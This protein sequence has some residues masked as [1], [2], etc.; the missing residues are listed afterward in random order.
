MSASIKI[1]GLAALV[2]QLERLGAVGGLKVC[3]S[4]ARAAMKPVELEAKRLA[5][6]QTTLLER[7]IRVAVVKPKGGTIVVSAGLA[8]RKSVKEE[9]FTGDVVETVRGSGA[10]WRWHL[11]EFGVPS[12]GI[13]AHP[14]IR[15]A[16]A[17]KQGTV[18]EVFKQAL[19]KKVTAAIRREL[20]KDST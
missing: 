6:K 8:M 4:A 13:A 1:E 12:R 3:A 18:V 10:G 16:F 19:E 5:P 9:I 17:S 15:P 20:A 14:F 11:S 2:D 7:T